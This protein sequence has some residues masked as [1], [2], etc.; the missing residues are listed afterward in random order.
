[1]SG[2][3]RRCGALLAV[4]AVVGAAS[5]AGAGRLPRYG[6]DFRFHLSS[7]APVLDPLRLGDE[8]GALIASCAFEGLTRWDDAAPAPAIAR[9]WVRDEDGK[10]WMFELRPD[11]VFHDGT[12]CDAAA[13]R[14]SLERLADPRQSPHAWVLADVVGWDAFAAGRTPALDGIDVISADR[15]EL[16]LENAVPDLPA[17]LAL[18][19][20]AIAR[21]RGDEFVGTGPYQLLARTPSMLRLAAFRDHYDGR[22]YIDH[23][24][25]VVRRDADAPPV[26]AAGTAEL[27]RALVADILPAGSTRWRAPAE[28]LGL[29]VVHPGSAVLRDDA[30]RDKLAATFDRS[31]FVRAVLGGDG[32]GTESLAPRGVKTIAARSPEAAGDLGQRPQ[33]KVR[34]IV[35]QAEPVL[36]A[37]GER[38]QVHLFA[39]GVAADLDVLTP[40]ALETAL[41]S[42]NWDVAVLG[43]TPPQPGVVEF[44]ATARAQLLA[45]GVLQ[46]LLRDAMPEAWMPMRLRG[47]RDAE[48]VL[49]R[50]NWC[51]PLVLF[52]DLWQTGSDL[53]RFEPGAAAA[54][55][56][57]AN[58]HFAPRSP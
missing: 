35:L 4:T 31:I 23:V 8:D 45:A 39:L 10:R 7:L 15:I 21:R 37:L 30:L 43:W 1:M 55:L 16:R 56:G 50:G 36:R 14:Q 52:H 29:A 38:L 41:T 58:A 18:P 34:I 9:Q 25:L 48:Q 46:P 13:I 6:G 57:V 27:K 28:R 33:Q 40:E 44:D 51:I 26:A 5:V 47:A 32:S 22:P 20:A 19:M 53:A 49:L 12:R 2:A 24:E 17:R 54:G 3:L 42:R 11:V